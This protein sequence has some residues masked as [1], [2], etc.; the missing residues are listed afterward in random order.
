MALMMSLVAMAI[1]AML[2][3]LAQI[4]EDLGAG[5]AN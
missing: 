5:H 2:P 3:A 1:D 4:G